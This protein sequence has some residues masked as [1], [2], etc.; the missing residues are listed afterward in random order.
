FRPSSTDL[1]LWNDFNMAGIDTAAQDIL[2]LNARSQNGWRDE[3]VDAATLRRLYDL[4]KMGPTSANCSPMRV[5]FLTTPAAIERLLPAMS[6]GNQDKTR[7][8]PVVA[9]LAYDRKFYDRIP[10][11]FPHNPGAREWF[12]GSAQAAETTA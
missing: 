12:T 5:V 3:P 6:P 9:L 4:M 2:F 10:Q 1:H 7:T 8:A 11:L